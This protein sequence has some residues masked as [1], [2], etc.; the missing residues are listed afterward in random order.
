MSRQFD[1]IIVG[2]GQSGPPLAV[3]LAQAGRK[4]ALVER[5]H[6]GGTCVND[7]CTPT[8]AMVAS[9]RVAHQI[10]RAAEYGIGVAG[11]VSIDMRAVK[12]R[13]DAI[14]QASVDSLTKWLT[15][16]DNLTLIWG[17][18]SFV[19]PHELVVGD[20][21]LV[22]GQ[23]FLDTGARAV[24]PDWP[25]LAD[26]PYLTN[27]TI[28]ELEDVPRHLVIVGGGAV[29]LEFGQ[30]FRRFGSRVTIIEHA[31]RLAARED[32]DVSQAIHDIMNAEGIDLIYNARDF[33]VAGHA[34][35]LMLTMTVPGGI[36]RVSGSHLLLAMGRRPNVD[37][38]NPGAAGLRLDSRG[39]IEV[40]DQLRTEVEGIWALGE[41]NG[42]GAF[43]HTSYNDFE[44]VAANLL[45][46]DPRRVSDRILAYNLYIDP[47]L[48]RCGMTE[49]Q[50]RQ[51]G[52][53]ALIGKIPMTRVSR[54]KEKGE[55]TG[56]MKVLVDA[57]SKL[58]LGAAFLCTGG[59]EIVHSVL[60]IMAARAPYT[61]IQR[62]VH[63]HPTV[64]ELIPTMLGDL[65]PL[66]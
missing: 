34:D 48:G 58:I 33:S 7:G 3:R 29:G 64:S 44:I 28:L 19:G 18:A 11:P 46:N 62:T 16:T 50:V 1:A 55:T 53:P 65:K 36:Q 5:Q 25:G 6:L 15:G 63:I 23:I 56:F 41:V 27:T 43:T 49:A 8:K 30:M 10:R 51:R 57:E 47:P 37:D 24:V 9:A 39:H 59:D 42:H 60:D 22:A 45:D 20:E 31:P 61:V 35:G 26:I 38:L 52:R 32:E 4:V 14:V 66:S 17:S 21:K 12:A 54:A 40:D 13:K 2:A